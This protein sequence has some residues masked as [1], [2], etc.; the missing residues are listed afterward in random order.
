MARKANMREP[1]LEPRWLVGLLNRWAIRSLSEQTK[2][3]G[4]YGTNPMLRSGIPSPA[5]SYEPTGYSD[6]DFLDAERAIND[7]ELMK[8]LAVMRYFKPWAKANIDA[9]IE[10]DNDTWMYHLRDALVK[11][12]IALARRKAAADLEESL[13]IAARISGREVEQS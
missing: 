8:R 6:V 4:Y 5:K 3:L 11:I 1:A 13:Q 10:R 7:L 9:E 12:E 2:G